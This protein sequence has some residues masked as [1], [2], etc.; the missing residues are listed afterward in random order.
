MFAGLGR[1]G[2]FYLWSIIWEFAYNDQHTILFEEWLK[3]V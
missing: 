2:Y 1:L 3:I